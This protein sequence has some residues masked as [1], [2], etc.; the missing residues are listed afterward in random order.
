MKENIAINKIELQEVKLEFHEIKLEPIITKIEIDRGLIEKS[1]S[2]MWEE[3]KLR[4]SNR[5]NYKDP[6]GMKNLILNNIPKSTQNEA[7]L[8]ISPLWC[9]K[10][11]IEEFL[12]NR[13][14]TTLKEF[15]GDIKLI[16]KH[17]HELYHL[18]KLMEN[19]LLLWNEGVIK[20]FKSILEKYI[21]T[22]DLWLTEQP[23]LKLSILLEMKL[24][25]NSEDENKN[26]IPIASLSEVIKEG[27]AENYGTEL[28]G[29]S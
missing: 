29:E 18:N 1:I 21:G 16:K 15:K 2:K 4:E 14:N 12:N 19:N 3:F 27:L 8:V 10:K 22:Q 28:I 13:I 7:L 20:A 17:I 9:H 26:K 5:Y 11:E 24:F 25:N 23:V 6:F